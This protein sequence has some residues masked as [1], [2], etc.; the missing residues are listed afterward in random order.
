MNDTAIIQ[1]ER[2][3]LRALSTRRIK[4]T[5]WIEIDRKLAGYA[6]REPD[7]AVVYE[8]IVR[9]RSRDPDHWR[10]QLAAQT[11]RMGF[12]DLDWGS[13]VGPPPLGTTEASFD[14]LIR[15]LELAIARAG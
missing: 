12:P 1:A 7:H 15:E 6:W 4:R 3:V 10:E 2:L 9:A 14:Q 5:E 8:A 13:L 11:T